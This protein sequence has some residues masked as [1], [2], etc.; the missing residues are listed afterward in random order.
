MIT[1]SA[2]FNAAAAA[3]LSPE[4]IA[5]STLRTELRRTARRALFTSVRRAI[6]RVALR[7][8]LVLAIETLVCSRRRRQERPRAPGFFR[9]MR[10]RKG[11]P[12]RLR[13][14]VRRPA[15]VNAA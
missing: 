7:A 14:I 9:K 10:R 15:G 1:G 6:T 8:D 5:S 3:V 12:P 4:A 13:L 11:S 2:A